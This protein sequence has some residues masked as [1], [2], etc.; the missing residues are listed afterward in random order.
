MAGWGERVRHPGAREWCGDPRHGGAGPRRLRGALGCDQRIAVHRGWE[1]GARPPPPRLRVSGGRRARSK[2][3]H[4]A[5]MD[6]VIERRPPNWGRVGRRLL[7]WVLIG[8]PLVLAVAL[9]ASA[10]A[11]Y[12]ARAGVE[13]ARILLKRRAIAKLVA[14]PKTDPALRQRL[15][16][17]LAARAYAA[18]SLG[19]LLGGTY[20]THLNVGRGTLRLGVTAAPR[21]SSARGGTRSTPGARSR[22]GATSAPWTSCTRSSP[23]ASIRPT[24]KPLPGRR[25]SARAEPCSRGRGR[26]SRARSGN[27][28]RRTTGAG[29]PG[30]PSTTRW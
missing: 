11:R 29:S 19:L 7:A 14:D 2:A 6:A 25:S 26:S 8:V 10:D 15:R 12:I 17:L 1:P 13:E 20:T 3:P 23:A 9:A 18:D 27:H 21:R 16:L 22:A 4:G 5:A 24:R 30:R 28:S